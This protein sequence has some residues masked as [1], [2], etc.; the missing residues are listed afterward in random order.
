MTQL[1]FRRCYFDSKSPSW[2]SRVENILGLGRTPQEIV[3]AIQRLDAKGDDMTVQTM[4]PFSTDTSL[5]GSDNSEEDWR[6]LSTLV[7]NAQNKTEC[8]RIPSFLFMDCRNL[9]EL[10]PL[11]MSSMS[12]LGCSPIAPD[13]G[14]NLETVYVASAYD[15]T[16][17]VP[18]APVYLMEEGSF[19][20]A[21]ITF[22]KR[23]QLR[24]FDD[25]CIC[26]CDRILTV[27]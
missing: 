9:R 21:I 7:E 17:N 6:R 24:D 13:P 25:L 23:I 2:P 11:P 12:S 22:L 3:E 16:N 10:G 15:H 19:N 8:D 26:K 1:F 5:L 4:G 20:Q 27:S 18:I 14:T